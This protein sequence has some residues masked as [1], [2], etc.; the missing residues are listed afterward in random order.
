[1][2]RNDNLAGEPLPATVVRQQLQKLLSSSELAHA[3][4]LAKLLR[5]V[6]VETLEGRA[7]Q[8]KEARL[9]LEVFDRPPDSYDPAVDPIVRVQMGRLRAKL[10]SYYASRGAADRV[11]I[12]VPT[13]SYVPRF[14]S[15][16][17]D[18][19]GL[20]RAQTES[21]TTDVRLAVLP[22]VN[23]SPDPDNECFCDGLTEELINRLAQAGRI[24]VV[25]RTSS[26]QFKGAARDIRDVGRQLEVSQILEGS[27]R[28]SGARIRVT[29]QLINVADGC[30][31]WS[32]RYEGDITDIFGIHEEISRAI[33][34]ALQARIGGAQETRPSESRTHG[35]DAYNHYLQGRFLWKKR[36]EQ[37]LS[38]AIGHF[39]QAIRLDPTFARAHSGLADCHLMLGMSAAKA[40]DRCMPQAAQAARRALELDDRLAEA[41]TSLAAVENCYRWDFPAAEAGYLRSLALDPSYATT[42][43]WYGLFAHAS[44]GRFAEALDHLEQGVALDPLSPPIIADL[45]LVHAFCHD[46]EAAVD[47][48]RR[49]LELDPHFHRPYWFLGLSH[50]WNGDFAAAEGALKKGLELCSGQAFRSRLMGALGFAYGR[51]GKDDLFDGVLAE[52]NR[53]SQSQYVPSFDVAQVHAG[54]GNTMAA[55]A[56]LEAAVGTRESFAIFLKAWPSFG[57]LHSEPRFRSLLDRVGLQP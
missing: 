32:E 7:S 48:C 43:H 52:L 12:E 46:A 37:G 38:A 29:V 51:W 47:Q 20:D 18:G 27:V 14:G 41:H 2:E 54:R 35:I 33:Q 23:M 21:A 57:T 17:F 30:H 3:E 36:T 28:K 19:Q 5:F 1:V 45:G 40:P 16:T 39:G 13:G 56:C 34:Q 6:V 42:H 4:R 11:L 50:A 49:A 25:A 44:L 10:R 15:R 24:R 31:L 55:L 8:L 9:G 53:L 22:F 26:F